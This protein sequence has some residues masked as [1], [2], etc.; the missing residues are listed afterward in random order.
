MI[1]IR[2]EAVEA[3]AKALWDTDPVLSRKSPWG[4]NRDVMRE[5]IRRSGAMIAAFCEA[6]GL[7]VERKSYATGG[8]QRLPRPVQRL[9]G[10]WREVEND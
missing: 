9:M 7:T 4:S 3:A 8:L 6:E 1:E 10:P 5:G 2:P